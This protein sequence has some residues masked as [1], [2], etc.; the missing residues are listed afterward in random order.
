MIN[1]T[2]KGNEKKKRPKGKLIIMIILCRKCYQP[3][4]LS[5]LPIS[6]LTW[7]TKKMILRKMIYKK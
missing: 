1:F 7:P 6:K 4:L 2:L 3:I 5:I